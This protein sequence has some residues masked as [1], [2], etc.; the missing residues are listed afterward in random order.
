M[1]SPASAVHFY[2]SLS[3]TDTQMKA[4]PSTFVSVCLSACIW[5]YVCVIPA[6]VIVCLRVCRF[7]C[8]NAER[9]GSHSKGQNVGYWLRISFNPFIETD[10]SQSYTA[11]SISFEN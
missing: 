5:L 4:I 9:R 10:Q 6:C 11:A 7:A 8:G 2:L 3:T 1:L